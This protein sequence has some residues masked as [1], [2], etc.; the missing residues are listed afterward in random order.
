MTMAQYVTESMAYMVSA[1]MDQVSIF[2]KITLYMDLFISLSTCS[3]FIARRLK[4]I[5]ETLEMGI[6][7]LS[8]LL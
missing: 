5:K 7:T 6:K 3:I 8:F 1:N 2:L 4:K